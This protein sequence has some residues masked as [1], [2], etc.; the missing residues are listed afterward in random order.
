MDW[1][2]A[3][4]LHRFGLIATGSE[5]KDNRETVFVSDASYQHATWASNIVQDSDFRKQNTLLMISRAYEAGCPKKWYSYLSYD[6]NGARDDLAFKTYTDYSCFIS[7]KVKAE[8]DEAFCSFALVSPL[9]FRACRSKF[10]MH[11]LKGMPLTHPIQ[12]VWS[13][14]VHQKTKTQQS[15]AI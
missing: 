7:G 15:F 12:N 11:P 10:D 4:T 1:R 3:I 9:S 2:K 6:D 13:N 14:G 8:F 5:S